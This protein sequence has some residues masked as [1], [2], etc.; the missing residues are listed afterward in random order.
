MPIINKGTAFSNGEQL[1]ADKINNLLD[2]AT[3]N[4]SATDSAS[5]TVNSASQIVVADSG[6]TPTKLSTGA[7]SWDASGHLILTGNVT[8]N[9]D[10]GHLVTYGGTQGNGAHIELYSGGHATAAN[11]AYYDATEHNF[12]QRSGTQLMRLNSEGTLMVG[13]TDQNPYD[14]GAASG[15]AF[16]GVGSSQAGLISSARLHQVAAA[17][18]RI[19]SDG[20]VVQFSRSGVAVGNISV[21]Q[22]SVSYNSTSDYRL[23]EDIIEL[24]D[25]IDRL[26]A[27]KPCNF[28]WKVDGTRMD[29]F[30]AHELQEVVPESA[31]GT[32]DAVKEDGTPDYQGIDQAKLIPLLTKA[33]QEAIAR[34]EV[35]EAK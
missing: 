13:T 16:H 30:I 15:I 34:I 21:T 27:L 35:L 1:T 28:A 33:L 19:G 3:F 5:T 29:G 4:Q 11:K 9:N 14:N 31:T 24:D 26:K 20:A 12:R 7:P 2:L 17:F 18:N 22:S 6:I 32:K 8:N 25:S 23:K 10:I